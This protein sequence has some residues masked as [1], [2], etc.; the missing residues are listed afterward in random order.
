MPRRLITVCWLLI[1]SI[2]GPLVPASFCQEAQEARPRKVFEAKAA[3]PQDIDPKADDRQSVTP[4]TGDRKV[5]EAKPDT[6]KTDDNMTVRVKDVATIE[7]VRINQLVGYGVVV[8]LNRTG[9]QVQQNV[10]AAQ[11]LQNLL[12][13]MGIS[14]TAANLKPENMATV[15]ITANLPPFARPGSMIDVIVSTVGDAHS[16]QG[17]TL[18]MSSLKGVDGKIYAIAQ[19]PVSI[20]GV[21]AGSR[22]NSVEVNHPT[23]GRIPNGA[24]VERTVPIDLN[25]IRPLTLV[26]REEDFTTCSRLQTTVN[27]EFGKGSA[28]AVDGRNVD[29]IVPQ[30]WREDVVGFI[31]RLESLKLRTDMVARV[32]INERTGTIVI[33]RDVR[34]SSVAISQ[35]GVTVRVGTELEVSQPGPFSEKGTTV[36][37]PRTTVAVEERKAKS[38]VLPDG[39][40]IEEVVR[41]LRAVGVTTSGIIS[42]LQAVKSAGALAADL[43]MQ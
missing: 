12:E 24:S 3:G 1:V 4:K 7:G 13:R 15:M 39:A 30:E 20:G 41:G 28:H 6:R 33:G 10:F 11:T 9:D 17:G 21:A 22:G 8:G 31:A 5:E 14:T 16:L 29:V 27:D 34:I 36:T 32:V 26:L 43:E 19:G 18:V 42:I 23:A 2:A 40:S 38:L 25:P 37:V 35:G